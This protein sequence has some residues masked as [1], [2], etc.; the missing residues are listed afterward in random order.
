MIYTHLTQAERYQIDILRKANHSQSEI[1]ALLGRDKSC[2]S[3][4]LRRNLGQRGY[5]PKQ[6]HSLAQAGKRQLGASIQG[7]A[8]DSGDNRFADRMAD[9]ARPTPALL[10][11]IVRPVAFPACGGLQIRARAERLFACA[12]QH[13]HS[14]G[15]ITFRQFKRLAQSGVHRGV[16]GVPRVRSIDRYDLEC[17]P[18]ARPGLLV[19][20]LPF[21]SSLGAMVAVKS[22]SGRMP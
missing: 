7:K 17:Y 22:S 2:I 21:L 14:D 19:I 11:G 12:G 8:V 18:A 5:R 20:D 16:D 6:A 13:N 1:A 4:E 15:W 9:K 10:F 3:R